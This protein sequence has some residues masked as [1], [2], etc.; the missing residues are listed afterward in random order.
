M[1]AEDELPETLR[2]LNEMLK[3]LNNTVETSAERQ[4]KFYDRLQ[5]N[6]LAL[7]K[8]A[9]QVRSGTKTVKEYE[10]KKAAYEID[11][12]KRA[13]SLAQEQLAAEKET[14]T[15]AFQFMKAAG[16]SIENQKALLV[17]GGRLKA[18]GQTLSAIG[19]SMGSFAKGLAEGDTKFTSLNPLID[20]VVG[21]MAKLAEAIPFVGGAL[22]G[23]MKLAAE[24]AKFM[25]QQ[26]Q[27]ATDTF[28][29]L[30]SVG[31]LTTKGMS[32]V[33][34]Q[35]LRS[36]LP[37]ESFRRQIMANSNALATFRGSV[38]SG[39]DDF[40]KIVGAVV[41][42]A[43]EELR[44]L[45]FSADAMGEATAGF[46]KMQSTL[47]LAQQKT[48]SQL[49]RGAAEYAKELDT[50][51]KLTGQQRKQIEE[52]Q[53][54]ALS[55][56][57][58][59]AQYDEMVAQGQEKQAK[60]LLD[61]QT[62]VNALSPQFAAGIRDMSTGLTNSQAAIKAFNT[63]GG[64]VQ[65]IVERLKRGEIDQSQAMRELQ[66]ATKQQ[67]GTTRT[68]AKAMGDGNDVFIDY[69]QTSKLVNAEQKDLAKVQ[70][71][72]VKQMTKGQD[73]LTDAAVGAQQGLEK[74]SREVSNLAFQIL[75]N[76]ASVLKSTT[77]VMYQG[78]R[79]L[80]GALG[81]PSPVGGGGAG[82]GGGGGAGAAPGG[83]GGRGGRGAGGGGAGGGA[84][85]GTGALSDYLVFG[86]NTGSQANFDAL[87]TD[88]KNRFIAM[89]QEYN[90]ITGDKLRINSAYRSAEDQAALM[91]RGGNGANPIAQPG[92]SLHQ[93][94]IAVDVNSEQRRT[95]Q[96]MGLLGKYNMSG[97]PNDPPHIQSLAMGGVATGPKSGYAATLHGNEAVVPLPDGRTIPVEMPS[98]SNNIEQQVS[99]LGAQ[100]ATMQ[101]MVRYMR[102]GNAISTKLLQAANN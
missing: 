16:A 13:R 90:Q 67:M 63:T 59:R 23:A 41:D 39:A 99:M 15:L 35:F 27:V 18:T 29:E 45:G 9:Q 19:G 79:K 56:G 83:R 100:L 20:G 51:A 25:N 69:A 31:A 52:Q 66:A 88:F 46:V 37:L 3:T 55:E 60:A 17:W 2:D 65:G 84:A 5:N 28:Q 40:S 14:K 42:G 1:A 11:A 8:F 68:F 48:N 6:A 38:G 92:M 33:Q 77:D 64:A 95:L 89:A 73:P 102:D 50:L 12:A 7:E 30:S 32:G 72:A 81:V 49:A 87:D 75:P 54:A 93:R 80:S 61:F 86:G 101:E 96:S 4:K 44:R 62:Q 47:G 26:L 53:D 58:F 98:L 36:G 94:G 82:G 34:E 24:G 85:G 78:I 71:D 21:A 57:R 74:M 22:S 91:A 43:G 76:Y 70:A 97:L 10:E